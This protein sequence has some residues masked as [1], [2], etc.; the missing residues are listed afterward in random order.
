MNT[1]SNLFLSSNK[2][3]GTALFPDQ[4]SFGSLQIEF[5]QIEYTG[6]H[7]FVEGVSN[8][9]TK[10][11]QNMD[12]TKRPIH[13]TDLKR[14]ILYVKDNES[15]NKDSDDKGKMKEAIEKVK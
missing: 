9:F 4:G 15:W 5:S 8:I 11:I 14:E 10:A 1:N 13:C 12:I 2:S 6:V 3:L 7:G